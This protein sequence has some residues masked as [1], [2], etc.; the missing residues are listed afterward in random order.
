MKSRVKFATFVYFLNGFRIV[1]LENNLFY[2]R[3]FIVV[4]KWQSETIVTKN[5]PNPNSPNILQSY[6]LKLFLLLPQIDHQP[7]APVPL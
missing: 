2:D 7:L 1:K 3:S 5:H 4:K 6:Q